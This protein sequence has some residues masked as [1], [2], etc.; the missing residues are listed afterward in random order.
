VPLRTL[1]TAA[2]L[3]LV[4]A[5]AGCGPIASRSSAEEP[6]KPEVRSTAGELAI[7]ATDRGVLLVQG[8]D[9]TEVRLDRWGRTDPRAAE[10]TRRGSAPCPPLPGCSSRLEFGD[11]TLVAWYADLGGRLQLGFDVAAPPPGGGPLLFEVALPGLAPAG[12]VPDGLLM[13]L[14]GLPSLRID[15]LAAWDADGAPLEAWMEGAPGLLRVQ[16][17]D[18]GA[19]YPLVVDPY[20]S[21]VIAWEFIAPQDDAT[22]GMQATSAGDVNADG[23]D[24]LLVGIPGLDAGQVSEGGAYLFLG[25][26]TGLAAAASWLAEG[27]Q[28]FAFLGMSAAPAGDIDGDGYGDV[29][30]GAPGWD[31]TLP[32]QGAARLYSG[33]PTGLAADPAWEVEGPLI[34]GFFGWT[35]AGVGDLNGDGHGDVAVGAPWAEVGAFEAGLAHVYLGSATGLPLVQDWSWTGQEGD[36]VG[37]GLAGDGDVDGDGFHDLVVGAP[38]WSNPE[39]G[40]GAAWLFP[41]SPSGPLVTPSWSFEPDQAMARAGEALSVDG[42]FDEDG[43]A[44]VLVG[45]PGYGA[46]LAAEGAVWLFPGS[47]TGPSPTWTWTQTSGE[48]GGELGA[49]VAAVGDVDGDGFGDLVAGAP[50]E[51]SDLAMDQGTVRVWPGGA[52]G[53]AT[54]P[55]IVLFGPQW[56]GGF[57]QS[58]GPAGDVNGDGFADVVVGAPFVGAPQGGAYVFLGVPA[59]AD[60]DQ[61][62]YCTNI[63]SCPGGLEPGDCDDTDP[64][65]HPGAEEACNGLDDDCD[66]VVPIEEADDDLDEWRICEGDCDDTDGLVHPEA[67]EFCDGLD[68]DCDGEVDEGAPPIAWFPDDDQ[69]GWGD[70]AFDPYISCTPPPGWSNSPGD[71][72]DSNPN[73][74]PGVAEQLCNGIDDDCDVETEDV[75]DF[76]HDGYTACDCEDGSDGDCGDCDDHEIAINPEMWDVC[77]DGLDQDCDG[78]DAVCDFEELC[79]DP[80]NLCRDYD[81][82]CSQARP[83]AALPLAAL[84]LPALALVRRRR[85]SRVAVPLLL[86]CALLVPASAAADPGD[87]DTQLLRPSFT[88]RGFLASTGADPG[89][90]GT[91]RVGATF[92]Y[93]HVPLLVLSHDVEAA[94]LIGSRFSGTVGGWVTIVDGLGAELSLPFYG[95]QGTWDNEL[96]PGFAMGD[97]RARIVWRFA[98]ARAFSAALVGQGFLP[99]STR[100]AFAGERRPR[101]GLGVVAQLDMGRTSLALTPEILFRTRVRTG[102]DFDLG[103]ELG[104]TLAVKLEA[105]RDLVYLLAELESRAGVVGFLKYP[106]ESPAEVRFGAQFWPLDILRVDL[107]GGVGLG[108]GYGA[109]LFRILAGIS[110]VREPVPPPEIVYVEEPEPPPPPPPEPEPEPE[111]EPEAEPEPLAQVEGEQITINEPIRFE[112]DSDVLL[113]ESYPVLDAVSAILG[114]T[115][116]IAHVLI[117]GHA[118]VEG[119]VGYNWDL[120]NRRAASVF[121]Y[122][123][124][125][126]VNA[127]RLSYRGMGEAA[128]TTVARDGRI[129]EADRRVEFHIVRELNEWVDEIPDWSLGAP[130]VP[131]TMGEEELGE[132]PA[133]ATRPAPSRSRPTPGATRP[134]TSRPPERS[135]QPDEP[136]EPDPDVNWEEPGWEVLEDDPFDEGEDPFDEAILD[137]GDDDDD[138][139]DD[140]PREELDLEELDLEL[141]EGD[142]DFEGVEDD[143]LDEDRDPELRQD[144][145]DSAGDDDDSAGDDDDSADEP[146]EE[147]EELFLPPEPD[148]DKRREFE[149]EFEDDPVPEEGF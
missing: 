44:D 122:L 77:D 68:Q 124:E 114:R 79:Q 13:G 115:P 24:D 55:G 62:G 17:D 63:G 120:S 135:S 107:A 15:G 29:I 53:P 11:D 60:L 46:D 108:P 66:G 25:S 103:S 136:A 105:K 86:A 95:Q 70:P 59:D 74:H 72:N 143:L 85:R 56:L 141:D 1:R 78:S 45:G 132:E 69:D 83:G 117:E 142:L 123:V 146:A 9:R 110:V 47:A 7:E 48:E 129:I 5:L 148:P 145:D 89:V 16:V 121:R 106:G 94:L 134:A 131:W 130:P 49:S 8:T 119:T 109:P 113:P 10:L 73:V 76:D 61:D 100:N 140:S 34:D 42:D 22:L 2:L 101:G 23:F 84:L 27:G 138:D 54:E 19:R 64:D 147:E 32:D 65:R 126:G 144:D 43:L 31:G 111:V 50:H 128:P 28:P 26:A 125:V 36:Q 88:P 18:A 52:A 139:D 67:A 57:G 14:D 99:T 118:S 96:L 98:H 80:S 71:C 38:G 133:G 87:V 21:P 104:L 35:V 112:Y 41:G 93:E 81:C 37:F 39:T 137:E 82:A 75:V 12:T 90:A 51:D 102:Y 97:V 33:G 40:E 3:P 91:F 6:A 149:A 58:V 116:E 20:L 127:R 92:Q 30:V 4:A